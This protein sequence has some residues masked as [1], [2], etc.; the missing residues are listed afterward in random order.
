M[1]RGPW[2]TTVTSGSRRAQATGDVEFGVGGFQG[3]EGHD[4]GA[5]WF[6]ENQEEELDAPNEFFYD[7]ESSQLY[8]F[9]NGTGAPPSSVEVPGPSSKIRAPLFAAR[10]RHRSMPGHSIAAVREIK[11]SLWAT[12]G[13]KE[14]N[15]RP[16][17][18][19]QRS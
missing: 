3:A 7:R 19:S 18:S 12:A 15:I 5:E 17:R 11:S 2:A 1:A 10:T 13:G 6:V 8:L 16:K 9:F 14:P 4:S